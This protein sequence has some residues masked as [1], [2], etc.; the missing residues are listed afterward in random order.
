MGKGRLRQWVQEGGGQ[1][2]RDEQTAR[3][4]P[5]EPAASQP[6]L[7]HNEQ[8]R[9]QMDKHSGHVP[10]A[11]VGGGRC[12]WQHGVGAKGQGRRADADR[13][14]GA[15][16]Q[17]MGLCPPRGH[18]RFLQEPRYWPCLVPWGREN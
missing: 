12:C 10:R 8:Q 6:G 4:R 18:T 2:L 15:G 1:G 14:H 5:R 11:G 9:G 17:L 16:V 13:Q 7:H 3:A